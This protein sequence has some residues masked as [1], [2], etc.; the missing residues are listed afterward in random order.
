MILKFFYT[1]NKVN[2]VLKTNLTSL[3]FRID[4]D[5]DLVNISFWK[6]TSMLCKQESIE[7]SG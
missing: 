5:A 6:I 2:L 4:S 7:A 3:G 1:G